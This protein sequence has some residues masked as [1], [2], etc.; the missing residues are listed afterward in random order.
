[1]LVEIG[2]TQSAAV[3]DLLR[4]EGFAVAEHRDLGGRPRVLLAT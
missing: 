1:M 2:W 3:G 4:G